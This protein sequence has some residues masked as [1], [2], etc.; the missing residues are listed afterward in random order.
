ME[1]QEERDE[2][3]WDGCVVNLA[4]VPV[5]LC[6]HE[7]CLLPE[8][9]GDRTQLLKVDRGKMAGFELDRNKLVPELSSI[10]VIPIKPNRLFIPVKHFSWFLSKMKLML[11]R[12]LSKTFHEKLRGESTRKE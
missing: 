2:F 6:V 5:S 8:D 11:K 12:V 1:G 4:V 3:F 7:P 9:K 10:H